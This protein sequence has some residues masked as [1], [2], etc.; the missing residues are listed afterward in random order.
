MP[1]DTT[2]AIQALARLRA[3][4]LATE[5]QPANRHPCITRARARPESI[6]TIEGEVVFRQPS[7]R[8]ACRGTYNTAVGVSLHES[9]ASRTSFVP[10]GAE[11]PAVPGRD[12]SER[13]HDFL[14][15][16]RQQHALARSRG[17]PEGRM[18]ME[19]SY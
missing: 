5:S 15:E 7:R 14:V 12:S 11:A 19:S 17:R 18:L 13:A 10:L 16:R 1:G 4:V 8:S 3:L 2:Q 9:A 6:S